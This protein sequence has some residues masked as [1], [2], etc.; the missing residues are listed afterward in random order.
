VRAGLDAIKEDLQTPH[1]SPL[2]PVDD[3]GGGDASVWRE[4]L[5]P[6]EVR[7][8][9]TGLLHQFPDNFSD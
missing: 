3:D 1:I 9:V 4:L 7:W 8:Q 6:Y 2:R 5:A